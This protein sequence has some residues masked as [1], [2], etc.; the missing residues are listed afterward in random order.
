[1]D[2]TALGRQG[3]IFVMQKLLKLGWEFPED[4]HNCM[5][6]LDWIF[7]KQNRKIKIQVK[8][9]EKSYPCFNFSLTTFDYLIFT[10]LR[11]CYIIPKE[12]ISPGKV[13]LTKTFKKLKN[14]FDLVDLN[15]KELLGALI[16]LRISPSEFYQTEHIFTKKGDFG[17]T[18]K[19]FS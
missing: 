5:D 4:Y 17:Q 7:V 11:D 16:D 15:G 1:M 10:N 18:L 8:C 3:E 6:G 9:S 2:K 14:R 13:R 12:L 19:C